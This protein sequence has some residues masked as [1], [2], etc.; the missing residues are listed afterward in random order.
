MA[1]I[2]SISLGEPSIPTVEEYRMWREIATSPA[3]ATTTVMKVV[4]IGARINSVNRSRLEQHFEDEQQRGEIAQATSADVDLKADAVVDDIDRLRRRCI[5]IGYK[6][7]KTPQDILYYRR[8]HAQNL[9]TNEKKGK[10]RS[11]R[12]FVVVSV[13][14]AG[15]R[16]MGPKQLTTRQNKAALKDHNCTSPVKRC[17]PLKARKRFLAGK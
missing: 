3:S 1:S 14:S 9:K 11:P 13:N 7:W 8:Q 17:S 10:L 4:H 12:R 6:L 16:V 2:D 5:K 15:R